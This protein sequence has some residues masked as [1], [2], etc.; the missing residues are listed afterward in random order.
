MLITG[1]MGIC[2]SGD[3][4]QGTAGYASEA[5]DYAKSLLVGPSTFR[6][7]AHTPSL[8]LFIYLFF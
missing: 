6:V 1:I 4:T 3:K 5:L 8:F 7:A 2:K